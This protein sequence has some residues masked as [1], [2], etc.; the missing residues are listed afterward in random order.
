MTNRLQ[1]LFDAAGCLKKYNSP[2]EICVEF[3]ETRKTKYIERKKF[4]MGMLKAQA[5]RLTNQVD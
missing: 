1:V 3:F 2:E 5:L 4:L